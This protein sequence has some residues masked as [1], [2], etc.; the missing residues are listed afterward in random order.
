MPEIGEPLPWERQLDESPAAYTAFRIY[1]DLG[2]SR[3]YD[4]ASRRYHDAARGKNASSTN[5]KRGKSGAVAIWAYKYKWADRARAWDAEQDRMIREAA[6]AERIAMNSRHAQIAVQL[7]MKAMERLKQLLPAELEAAEVL[8]YFTDAAKL[9]RLAR[10]EPDSIQEQRGLHSTTHKHEHQHEHDI[11]FKLADFIA[12]YDAEMARAA[13]L[14]GGVP[15]SDQQPVD[16][17]RADGQANGVPG[18]K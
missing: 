2:T 10:G 15:P 5:K 3:N 13:G 7:Q 9:E 17:A 4:E 11:R 8:K 12:R 6:V 14:P 16:E 1:R 18:H